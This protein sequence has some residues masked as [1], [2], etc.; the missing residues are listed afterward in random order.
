MQ[1]FFYFLSFV[2]NVDCFRGM[3]DIGPLILLKSVIFP[4]LFV[5]CLYHSIGQDGKK[6]PDCSLLFGKKLLP[7]EV[8]G[9]A[10]YW[11]QCISQCFPPPCY[12]Y[13]L[14]LLFLFF[15]YQYKKSRFWILKDHSI[16]LWQLH[17]VVT[18]NLPTRFG[19]RV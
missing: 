18:Q 17:A 5:I 3:G 19:Y 1:G 13:F 14:E 7:G 12:L 2:G 10:S 4:Y 16:Y 6:I 15:L 9:Y 11:F 8:L